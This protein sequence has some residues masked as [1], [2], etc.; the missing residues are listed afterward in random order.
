MSTLAFVVV[1]LAILGFGLVSGRVQRSFVTA[2]IVFVV[3]G[4]LVSQRVLGLVEFNVEERF[5]HLLAE[6]TL[7]LV[8]FTDASRIDLRLLRREH[9]LPV[10]LLSIGLPLTIVAGTLLA[11][12]VLGGLSFWEAA[13]VAVILAPTDAA[14]GQAVVS[15]KR[16]PVRI[17]QALNVE[18]GLNDGIAL[19]LVLIFLSFASIAA[20]THSVHYWA[21]FVALQV[22]LGPIVGIAV[23]YLG[24]RLISR[25]SRSGWMNHAFQDLGALGLSLLAF[26][27]AE[28]V[29]GNGFIAAFA[30]GLTIG[31]LS[32]PICECLYEFAEAEG[33][34]LTLVVFMVFGA[35][36]VPRIL[37]HASSSVVLYGV[38]SLTV[39]RM[40]PA[41]LSLVG[42][43][44]RWRTTLFLGWFGPRGIASILFALLVVEEACL[45]AGEEIIT[46]VMTTVLLSVFAH[47]VTAYPGAVWYARRVEAAGPDE[48]KAEMVEVTEMPVRIRH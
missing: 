28:L 31:N 18:S 44:L 22:V 38:L 34:L 36:M 10:R 26:A 32:R 40:L 8:L 46:I 25:A 33:Q 42:A 16:V 37:D 41:A 15:N 5:I 2:P 12:V 13:L 45:P 35:V 3:F 30:A 4:F 19:P 39:I 47:G 14:L 29:G 43:K 24:G 27:G 21:R 23:G 9:D 1:A 7:V 48:C 6:L 17:R 11:V 20:E